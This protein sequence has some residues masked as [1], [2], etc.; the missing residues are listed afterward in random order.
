MVGGDAAL[1]VE[2]E[3]SRQR[4]DVSE[5]LRHY[6]RGNHDAI[7]NLMRRDVRPHGLPA[8]IVH[9]QAQDG[10]TLILIFLLEF[11]EPGNFHFTRSAPGG[12]KIYQD[13]FAAIIRQIDGIAVSVFQCEV[14][15]L[16]ALAF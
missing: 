9:R 1:T 16:L 3:G 5:L 14:G 11:D 6:F 13:D 10:E 8:V 4:L 2:H 12:P 7:V 15:R